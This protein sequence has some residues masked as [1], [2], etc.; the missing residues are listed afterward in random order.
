MGGL[1]GGAGGYLG[2]GFRMGSQGEVYAQIMLWR[3]VLVGDVGV[4]VRVNVV[5]YG[6]GDSDGRRFRRIGICG[7]FGIVD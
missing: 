3:V 5:C 2:L 4:C 6:E 7:V 1:I